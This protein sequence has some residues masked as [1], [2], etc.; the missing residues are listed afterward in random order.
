MINLKLSS[1][2]S[3]SLA[4]LV[5]LGCIKEELEIEV[6]YKVMLKGEEIGSDRHTYSAY[7]R[8]VQVDRDITCAY[9]NMAPGIPFGPPRTT[10]ELDLL[11]GGKKC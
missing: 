7:F 5:E 1:N 8:G 10:I 6:S 11:D 3:S 9:R 2:S 4:R